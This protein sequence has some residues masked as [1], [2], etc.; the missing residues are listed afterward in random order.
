[1]TK[2]EAMDYLEGVNGK[3]IKL[4]LGPI[5]ALMEA[6]NWPDKQLKI[7]HITGTN[8]KGSVCEMMSQC[9]QCAGYTVGTFNSPYF[10]VCNECIRINNQMISDEV[11]LR[12]MNQVEPILHQLAQQEIEPSGFE[13][14]TALALLYFKEMQVDFVILEVGL[15]GRLDATN[16]IGKSLLTIVTKIAKDHQNFLGDSLED[17]AREKAGIIKPD[18]I[19]LMPV[20]EASVMKVIENKCKEQNAAYHTLSVYDVQSIEMNEKGICFIYKEE[21]YRLG[22]MGK[23]QAY[24]GSLAI[25]AIHLLKVYQGVQISEQHIKAGLERTL[26]PGR[27]E[28]MMDQPLCF[29]DGAHNVDGIL[30]LVDTLKTL[31]KR[32]TIAIVGMLRDKEVDEMLKVI[33]P[34]I[35]TCIVTK[36]LNPRAEEVE[37]LAQKVNH[38]IDEVYMREYIEEAYQLAMKLAACGEQ[39]QIIAFGSLYMLGKLRNIIGKKS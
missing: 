8:G 38:Y 10:E 4:G 36:P 5:T 37:V 26:W 12:L 30:A 27:F 28:K 29:I 17:I 1:M 3:T 7:I 33:M 19:V 11:L 23:Y 39:V 22:M 15:G 2:A 16:V 34:Y 9:L 35:D 24:N 25:E 14:L 18:G 20:Q 6:L 13:I 31:P 32:K 21:S